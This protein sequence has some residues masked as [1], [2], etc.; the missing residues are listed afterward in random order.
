[1]RNRLLLRLFSISTWLP[2]LATATAWAQGQPGAGE[3][4]IPGLPGSAGPPTEAGGPVEAPLPYIT[5]VTDPKI[6]LWWVL[7][8]AIWWLVAVAVTALF[9]K[10]NYPPNVAAIACWLAFTG[11]LFSFFIY[12]IGRLLHQIISIPIW[13]LLIV[14]S[15]ILLAVTLLR[16]STNI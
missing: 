3:E 8:L 13:I 1:M 10:R 5:L 12:I 16:R 2:L 4:P 7:L 6:I 15:L 14:V 9:G 11:A